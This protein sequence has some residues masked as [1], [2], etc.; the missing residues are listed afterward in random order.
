[1]QQYS[2]ALCYRDGQSMVAPLKSVPV[3]QVHPATI[4]VT[5]PCPRANAIAMLRIRVPLAVIARM[6]IGKATVVHVRNVRG[7]AKMARRGQ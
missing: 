7:T 4:K 6:A 2:V 3:V 1:M 5:V